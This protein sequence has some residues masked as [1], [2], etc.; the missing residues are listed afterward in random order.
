M[1]IILDIYYQP[2]YN[3]RLSLHRQVYNLSQVMTYQPS[4]EP[5][6]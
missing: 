3:P 1:F 4:Y 2:D 5:F 6:T